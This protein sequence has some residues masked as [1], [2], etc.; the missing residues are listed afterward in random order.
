MPFRER[1]YIIGVIKAPEE[2]NFGA[3]RLIGAERMF[4]HCAMAAQSYVAMILGSVERVTLED[5]E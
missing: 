5:L 2:N 4:R 1:L 3:V